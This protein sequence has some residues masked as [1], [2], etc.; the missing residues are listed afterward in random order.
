MWNLNE[1]ANQIITKILLALKYIT[2]KYYSIM[3]KNSKKLIS[4]ISQNR[5]YVLLFKRI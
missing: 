3:L 2:K 5:L 1:K 4:T